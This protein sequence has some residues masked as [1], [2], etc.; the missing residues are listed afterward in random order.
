MKVNSMIALCL[1]LTMSGACDS[2]EKKSDNSQA[3][4]IQ[5]LDQQV[6]AKIDGAESYI[7]GIEDASR[8]IHAT[9]IEKTL[10][11]Y[12]SCAETGRQNVELAAV[13]ACADG[14][15]SQLS[16]VLKTVAGEYRSEHA[17]SFEALNNQVLALADK[18]MTIGEDLAKV[19][20]SYT[21]CQD[22]SLNKGFQENSGRLLRAC[23]LTVTAE[24][25]RLETAVKNV[26]VIVI[27]TF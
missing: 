25:V 19:R 26:D 1:I 24:I 20:E 8:A 27:D 11:Q 21:S 12:N 9:A 22:D 7:S 10:D 5:S 4:A 17:K 6:N 14:F 23:E 18:G 15:Q 13:K 16:G 2:K 3:L